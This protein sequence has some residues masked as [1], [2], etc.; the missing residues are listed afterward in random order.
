MMNA[1][2][3][4][5]RGHL[6]PNRSDKLPEMIAPTERNIN[7]TVMP[8]CKVSALIA[9]CGVIALGI[10][11]APSREHEMR[12]VCWYGIICLL[13]T[14]MYVGNVDETTYSDS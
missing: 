8:H 1:V 2:R 6:R 13:A 11:T 3:L 10:T 4:A 14:A 9:I 5:M 7:V 12:L